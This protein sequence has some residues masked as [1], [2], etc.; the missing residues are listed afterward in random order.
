MFEN[1]FEY[2]FITLLI[3]GISALIG[4]NIIKIVELKFDN[5][6]FA[7]VK[8]PETKV[9]VHI[10]SDSLIPKNCD[11]RQER[12]EITNLIDK[13]NQPHIQKEPVFS[14]NNNIVKPVDHFEQ[15]Y[16]ETLNNKIDEVQ[17]YNMST[18]Y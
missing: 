3:V 16:A 18:F 4:L 5:I 1:K 11:C 12:K 10:D 8:V 9:T 17:P 14:P 15:H 2:I 13:L 6:Q 7:S